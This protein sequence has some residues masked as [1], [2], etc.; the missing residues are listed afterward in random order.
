MSDSPV[1]IGRLTPAANLSEELMRRL[2]PGARLPTEHEVMTAT[3]VSRTVV[4]EVISAL[5]AQGLVVTRQGVGAFVSPEAG[6]RPFRIEPDEVETLAEVLHVMELRLGAEAEA[7]GLAAERHT[8][9]QLSEIERRRQAVGSAIGQGES[10]VDADFVFHKAI[11]AATDNPHFLVFLGRFIIPRQAVRGGVGSPDEQ[12]A[13]LDCIQKEHGAIV[14]A[15]RAREP[16][17]ARAAARPHLANSLD[18][19][20]QMV[21]PTEGDGKAR[22]PGRKT[23]VSRR[24]AA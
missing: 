10:A 19:Y 17:Q 2:A 23:S 15:I 4:R 1:L 7:A 20:R 13:Y 16:E 3:G 9:A 18:R 21:A 6:R 24:P 22:R 14:A 5:R 8:A 11:F 12:R